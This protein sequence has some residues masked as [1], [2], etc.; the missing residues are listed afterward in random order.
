M[1]ALSTIVRS[2]ASDAELARVAEGLA[3]S[4]MRFGLREAQLHNM[5]AAILS[6]FEDSLS[7]EFTPEVRA[8][9]QAAFDRF[10]PM[11]ANAQSRL[12]AAG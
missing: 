1:K 6:A 4:H 10:V 12:A 8:A 9:W 5:C 7:G 3:R 11:V 2:L